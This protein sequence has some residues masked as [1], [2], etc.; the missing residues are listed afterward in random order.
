MFDRT[1]SNTRA[2]DVKLGA[3]TVRLSATLN[4]G[5]SGMYRP[6]VTFFLRG[7]NGSIAGTGPKPFPL[8]KRTSFSVTLPHLSWGTA[9]RLRR[10]GSLRL[11]RLIAKGYRSIL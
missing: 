8:L 6:H 3:H 11:Y 9:Y 10:V 7:P 2:Q 5:G 1:L 4:D